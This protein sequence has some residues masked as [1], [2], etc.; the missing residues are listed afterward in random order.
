MFP[1]PDDLRAAQDSID[2]RL[3][4]F[5]GNLWVP[6]REEFLAQQ[7]AR[8]A[9]EAAQGGEL[10]DRDEVSASGDTKT[11]VRATRNTRAKAKARKARKPKYSSGSSSSGAERSVRRRK[12]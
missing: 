3:R 10:P 6:T 9:A 4:H 7:E 12:K 2:H 1:D 11:N 5:G 8:E